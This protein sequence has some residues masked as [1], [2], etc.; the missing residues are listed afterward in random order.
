MA[1][2]EAAPRI[3][4][5]GATGQVG[6]E[7]RWTLGSLGPVTALARGDL[8]LD[9]PERIRA[10]VRDVRPRLIVNAA[11]YT[12]VDRAESEP[13]LA[14]VVNA[15][16]P[17][18]LAEEAARL[19]ALFVHYS[20][21][22]V[23]DG[24]KGAPYVEEDA[25]HPLSAYGE[26]KRDGEL[27]IAAV[28][29]PHLIFRTS[30]VYGARGPNFL[31]TMLRLAHEREELRVVS[32][33]VGA[34]TSGRA[35]AEMTTQVLARLRVGDGFALAT[36]DAGLHHASA[37]GST[38][39]HAFAHRILERDRHRAAQTCRR[40]VPLATADFPTPARRP[41]YSVLNNARLR[42]TFG[43]ALPPWEEQLDRVMAE[44]DAP[45]E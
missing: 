24:A 41:L 33:Q 17:R 8:P 14:H 38:S 6:S 30:W 23:F 25:T 39:W 10:V 15:V 5:A 9:D 19:G 13:G 43:I 4:L 1:A 2:E 11:A 35:L 36:E 28:G 7:L 34:P 20:T 3:L 40:I 45:R 26:S 37:A 16:A 42:T 32:D 21:D 12:A 18:V 29:G 22:Y 44:L 31:R 27:A